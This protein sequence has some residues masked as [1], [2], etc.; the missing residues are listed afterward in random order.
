[1]TM[2]VPELTHIEMLPM[3]ILHTVVS[4]LHPWDIKLLSCTSKRLRQACL[5]IL[6]RNIVLISLGSVL[7][8]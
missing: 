4:L 8:H 5:S 2:D 6:F 7:R 3:E 1:M